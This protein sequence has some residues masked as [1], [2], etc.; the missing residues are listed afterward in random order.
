MVGAFLLLSAF[1]KRHFNNTLRAITMSKNEQ[2][3]GLEPELAQELPTELDGL[4]AKCDALG[5][6]YHHQNGVEKLRALIKAHEEGAEAPEDTPAKDVEVK[7]IGKPLTEAQ[8]LNIKKT[9][10]RKR[11]LKLRRIILTCKNP[12]KANW[13]GETFGV[14]NSYMSTER[15]YVPFD[16]EAGYHVPQ[17][18]CD[19]ILERK[20]RK[21]PPKNKKIAGSGAQ[22][23]GGGLFPEFHIQYLDNLTAEELAEL[24]TI[25]SIRSGEIPKV[26]K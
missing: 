10:M 20:Y 25:Q 22:A 5:L 23:S 3:P 2:T 15:K 19:M 11:C 1:I 12:L 24:A 7:P 14:G 18:L 16:N 9:E 17:I 8:L 21:P 4:K 13:S 6:K 26:G